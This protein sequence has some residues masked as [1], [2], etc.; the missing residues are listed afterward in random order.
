MRSWVPFALLRPPLSLAE[1]PFA[2]IWTL[3]PEMTA[4]DARP[5]ELTIERGV[6]R[7]TQCR[8][9]LWVPADGADPPVENQPLFSTMS[10]RLADPRHVVI[11]QK[12]AVKVVWAGTY[13]VSEDRRSMRLAFEDHRAAN[14]L[15]GVIEYSREG[16]P[17]T[18][19]HSLSGAWHPIKLTALSTSGVTMTIRDAGD[20]LMMGWSDGRHV[21]SKLTA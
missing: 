19:A 5:V 11:V 21:E 3:Q 12:M 13:T 14:P 18:Q 20:G 9:P 10:V 17:M 2:G 8:V 1:N 4:F 7:R 6:Y 15:T 16:D